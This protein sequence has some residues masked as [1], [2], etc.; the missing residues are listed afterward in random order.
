RL[1][2]FPLNDPRNLQ[3]A[4]V[5]LMVVKKNQAVLTKLINDL[6]AIRT[7]TGEIPALVI[8]ADDWLFRGEERISKSVSTL[9]A[10]L[11]R[12]QYVSYTPSPIMDAF[13]DPT[14][15]KDLFP[16]D[17][18]VSLPRPEGYLGARDLHDLDAAPLCQP[19]LRH[20]P[21]DN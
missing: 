15:S 1:S 19:G 17:F 2:E 4:S 9:L 21:P 12:A 7:P 14:D 8:D 16:R 13:L 20:P 11:P 6:Q 18:I 10:I 5:R 3:S